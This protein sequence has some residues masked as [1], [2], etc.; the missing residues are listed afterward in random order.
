MDNG[1]G[2][3]PVKNG[4]GDSFLPGW[5]LGIVICPPEDNESNRTR[6]DILGWFAVIVIDRKG[7]GWRKEESL[8]TTSKGEKKWTTF[9]IIMD[10]RVYLL[11]ALVAV[12]LLALPFVFLARTRETSF[13]LERGDNSRGTDISVYSVDNFIYVP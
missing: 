3:R 13:N 8:Q 5:R 7:S 1:H 9:F 12:Y 4:K 10:R 11:S 2:Q 6:S